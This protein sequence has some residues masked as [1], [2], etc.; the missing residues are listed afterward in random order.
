MSEATIPSRGRCGNELSTL[1][2]Q[3]CTVTSKTCTVTSANKVYI[4]VRT[5]VPGN[6]CFRSDLRNNASASG[7]ENA[8]ALDFDFSF[9]DDVGREGYWAIPPEAELYTFPPGCWV[10]GKIRSCAT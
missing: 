7:A 2:R 8:P 4:T 10:G 6:V 3:A 1:I 9:E 5:N